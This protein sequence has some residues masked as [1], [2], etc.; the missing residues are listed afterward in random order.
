MLQQD[1]GGKP[2]DLGLGREQSQE[3]PAKADRLLT[4]TAMS[5]PVIALLVAAA[6]CAYLVLAGNRL[7][8]LAICRS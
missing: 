1:E 6:L 5:D 3:Q 4:E 7:P 8:P 2:H